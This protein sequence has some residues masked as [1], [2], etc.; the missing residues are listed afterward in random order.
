M[1]VLS[2]SLE[3]YLEAIYNII[4]EKKAVRAKDVAARL[5]VSNASVTGALKILSKRNFLNYAPYDVISLTPEGEK[6]AKEVVRRHKILKEFLIKVLSI[7]E[8]KADKAACQ[9]EHGISTEII[10]RLVKFI[11]F[12]EVCPLGGEKLIEGFRRHLK[13]GSNVE[14]CQRCIELAK[15]QVQLSKAKENKNSERKIT[16]ADLQPGQKAILRKIKARSDARKRFMGMGLTPG[17]VIYLERVA[18]MGDPIEIEVRGYNLSL[19]K[20]EAKKLEVEPR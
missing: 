14:E 5:N 15:S 20:D 13:C 11:E 4:Q 1:E 19:R 10:D 8:Q 17:A 6:I 3:D 18:P 2:A 7:D 16:L 9:L 12:I